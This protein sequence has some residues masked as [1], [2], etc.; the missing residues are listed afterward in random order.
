[1]GLPWGAGPKPCVVQLTKPSSPDS[2][3]PRLPVCW[4][5]LG[6]HGHYVTLC[7]AKW[8]STSTGS[9]AWGSVI[10]T[11][12]TKLNSYIQGKIG[13]GVGNKDDSSGDKL[14]EPGSGLLL[15]KTDP[16]KMLES[17]YTIKN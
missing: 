15:S 8:V 6:S 3:L 16:P 9:V 17:A 12:F 13:K 14:L 1:P 10:Q 11:G 2:A 5:D 4:L 7:L